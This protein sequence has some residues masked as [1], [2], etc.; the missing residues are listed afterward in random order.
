SRCPFAR[1]LGFLA[2]AMKKPLGHPIS[3]N[4]L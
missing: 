3:L 4:S 2:R 1:G